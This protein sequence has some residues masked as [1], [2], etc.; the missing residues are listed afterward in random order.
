MTAK[1]Q[2][3]W[4]I[5]SLVVICAIVAMLTVSAASSSAAHVH[6]RTPA[7][8]CDICFSVHIVSSE[9]ITTVN[10]FHAPETHEQFLSG[11]VIPGYRLPTLR[12]TVDRGPPS[13]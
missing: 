12:S 10:L 6:A 2:R 1:L 11:D 9:A 8:Q 5:R 4:F 13:L 7:G 3:F